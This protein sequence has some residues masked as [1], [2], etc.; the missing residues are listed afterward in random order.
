[1]MPVISFFAEGTPKGQPRPKAFANKKTGRA[2]V[3][4]PGTAEG[5]KGEVAIAAKPH[6]PEAPLEGPLRLFLNFILPRPKGHYRTGKRAAELRDDAPGWHTAKPDAD[7]FVK[8]V[9]DALT[10]L[11]FWRDDSQVCVLS[12]RKVYGNNVTGCEIEIREAT[13]QD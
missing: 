10:M 9:M 4:D 11:H 5:W 6:R 2:G 8:A 7:N 12:V 13:P 1:M 3:Y